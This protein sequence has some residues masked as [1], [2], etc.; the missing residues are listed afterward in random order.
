MSDI[1]LIQNALKQ[2]DI[3]AP[4]LFNFALEESIRVKKISCE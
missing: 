2:G 4:L 1:F 3:L